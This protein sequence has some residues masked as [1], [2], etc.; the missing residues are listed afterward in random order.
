MAKNKKRK[1]K[2][3][4]DDSTFVAPE[5]PVDVSVNDVIEHR[6]LRERRGRGRARVTLNLTSMIDVT[7]LLLVYFMVATEFKVGEEI[8]PLDLPSQ[9]QSQQERDPFDL[10]DQ[11]LR[12]EVATTGMMADDY[13]VSLQGSYSERPNTF[14]D[15]FEF[16]RQKQINDEQLGGLFLPDHSIIV[17][18]SRTTT[19]EH[20]IGAFNAAARAR[21]TN[22]RFAKPR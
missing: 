5:P 8:Y 6:S 12:I 4:K 13:R 17:S 20:A 22:I 3:K 9:L 15:L 2:P 11:P 7:F 21:Y 14:E 19:W 16:L 1:L 10:D 18:P